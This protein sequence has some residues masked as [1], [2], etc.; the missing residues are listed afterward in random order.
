MVAIERKPG[1]TKLPAPPTSPTLASRGVRFIAKFLDQALY[2]CPVLAAFLLTRAE[3]ESRD[4]TMLRVRYWVLGSG[5]IF[6]VQ[7]VLLTFRGQTLGKLAMGLRIVDYEE[8]DPPGFF[9]CVI[10]RSLVPWVIAFIPLF[11]TLFW[12]FDCLFIFG[13][14]RRCIHDLMA[15]TKVVDV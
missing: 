10:L 4:L 12:L 6:C 5:A 13:E 2:L 7:A 8:E 1:G 11:G 9:P 3:P 15:G 14:K